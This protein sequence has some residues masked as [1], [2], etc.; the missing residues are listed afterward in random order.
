[1]GARVIAVE[2]H[3]GRAARLRDRFG[4]PSGRVT[5]IQADAETLAAA[6]V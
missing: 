4:R 2:L 3:P 6:P 1:M 5:V